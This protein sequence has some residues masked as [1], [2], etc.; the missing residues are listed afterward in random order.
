MSNIEVTIR[1]CGRMSKSI[2]KV[3]SVLE[4]YNKVVKHTI[5]TVKAQDQAASHLI[6]QSHTMTN[7]ALS[8]TTVKNN[9]TQKSNFRNVLSGGMDGITKGL[10]AVKKAL[11]FIAPDRMKKISE[12]WNHAFRS[13]AANLAPKL[14]PAFDRLDELFKSE[15]FQ[16]FMKNIEIGVS[17]LIPVFTGLVSLAEPLLDVINAIFS[18]ITSNSGAILGILV[19]IAAAFTLITTATTIYNGILVLQTLYTK[20]AAIA[21]KGL[22]TVITGNPIMFIVKAVIIFITALITLIATV[23]PVREAF[24]RFAE[25]LIAFAENGVNHFFEAIAG[26]ARGLVQFSNSA[27]NGFLD[28]FVNPFIDGINLIAKAINHVFNKE[29][30]PL[31][32]MQV[33]FSNKAQSISES[34]LSHK[35]DLSD[36]QNT[37]GNGIRNSADHLSSLGLDALTSHAESMERQNPEGIKVK[38]VG[39]VHTLNRIN[40]DVN[41]AEDDIELLRDV[42]EREMLQNFVSLTPSVKVDIGNINENADTDRLMGKVTDELL[43]EIKSSALGVYGQ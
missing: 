5:D 28:T 27:I 11:T 41:V 39:M 22:N 1:A 13:M 7:A 14:K 19:G 35:I 20:M 4:K 3:Q 26:L 16:L 38:E 24:A 6:G 34:I 2:S 29:I 36:A 8:N 18:F 25:G 15:A 42:A 43:K 40:E 33:D 21:Q 32:H 30:K 10:G 37:V 23:E 31:D 9:K 12:A 17:A